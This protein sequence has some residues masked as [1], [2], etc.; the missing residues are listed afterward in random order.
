[1]NEEQ[2]THQNKHFCFWNFSNWMK[3]KK[4]GFW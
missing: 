2:I 3:N 1:M 4:L